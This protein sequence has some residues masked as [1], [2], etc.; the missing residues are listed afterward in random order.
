MGGVHA[1]GRCRSGL[2]YEVHRMHRLGN[3]NPCE[4]GAGVLALTIVR[5]DPIDRKMRSGVLAR[6]VSPR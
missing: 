5:L 6:R 1:A 2:P 3:C 4:L